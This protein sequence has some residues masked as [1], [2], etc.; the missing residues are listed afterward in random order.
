MEFGICHLD[1]YTVR[2]ENL[3][4]RFDHRSKKT[5]SPLVG[6]DGGEG[7]P[8]WPSP[9]PP[10]PNNKQ[11]GPPPSRAVSQYDK[12]NF[13]DRDGGSR[14]E[15]I[16]S[17][18]LYPFETKRPKRVTAAG[19]FPLSHLLHPLLAKPKIKIQKS[20]KVSF[21]NETRVSVSY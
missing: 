6:E 11:A 20:R 18:N 10:L 3:S 17:G 15:K 19:T 2:S 12:T 9:P 13:L 16:S 5:S 14:V 21:K 8:N 4:L 7:G 1:T